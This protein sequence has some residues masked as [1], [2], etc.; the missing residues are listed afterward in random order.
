MKKTNNDIQKDIC[1][2][3][4]KGIGNKE[5][6]EKYNIHRSTVQ[7]ILKRNNVE[8][9]KQFETSRKYNI[10]NFKGDIISNNDAYILGLIWADGNL[11]RNCIEISLQQTDEQ[12]LEDISNY[13]Y[14]EKVFSYRDSQISI[15]KNKEY[16]SKP[17]T[18]F[19]I[20]SKEVSNKLRKIGLIENKTLICRFPK[21]N[22]EYI[23][24]FLRGL[25]DGDGSIYIKNKNN[26]RVDIVSNPE[27][28]Q[29]ISQIV[30]ETLNINSKV[31]KKTEK[32]YTFTISG[33]LQILK[34][35]D[36]IYENSEL[37]LNRKYKKYR[38]LL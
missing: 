22:S 26:C 31:Y 33:R 8:L 7:Q 19:R 29:D 38:E 10:L 9:R 13:I 35:L 16:M 37:K 21:I 18:R 25:L 3:Y 2:E 34:F 11:S 5:L 1:E 17:Q 23:P 12:I 20:T 4:L 28:C 14:G 36:W 30:N 27:M 24:H 32:V 6:S 15:F